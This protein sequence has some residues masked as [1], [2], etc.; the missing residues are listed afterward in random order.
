MLAP[1]T[2]IGH[3]HTRDIPVAVV[4]IGIVSLRF[5]R[6]RVEPQRVVKMKYYSD[7]S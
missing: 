4:C 5:N 1:G 3:G 7:K 2:L 6:K